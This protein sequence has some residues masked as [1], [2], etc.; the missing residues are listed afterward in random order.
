MAP[1]TP[2][3][4]KPPMK[5]ACEGRVKEDPAHK[6]AHDAISFDAVLDRLLL[7]LGSP[8]AG[9]AA[10][11]SAAS[12][13]GSWEDASGEAEAT[14]GAGDAGGP[15]GAPELDLASALASASGRAMLAGAAVGLGRAVTPAQVLARA[16]VVASRRPTLDALRAAPGVTQ[17]TPEWYEAR[18][19]MVTASDVAQ[20]LGCAKFGNQRTFFQKKCGA[21]EEQAAF[22][23]SIPPLKWGVMFEPVAQAVYTAVNGGMRVHEFGLLRHKHPALAHVGASPDGI[24]DAGV[25]LEIKC[26]WR[27]RIVEGEVPLQYYYQIQAQLAVC[28]LDECDYFECEFFEV[29]G[30]EDDQWFAAEAEAGLPHG[31]GLF[32][33]DGPGPSFS[34]PPGVVGG[35]REELEAWAEDASANA[36]L[37]SSISDDGA[38]VGVCARPPFIPRRHWWVLR[39]RC[40]SRVPYDLEF[41][42]DMFSR[43]GR[44]WERTLLYRGDRARYLEEVG[45]ATPGAAPA[46]SS[47]STSFGAFGP[48]GTADKLTTGGYAFVD[49]P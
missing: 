28:G 26:P 18:Q 6:V 31:R 30:P 15:G 9:E 5:V 40:N 11:A 29:D 27:R 24:T 33:E 17:R 20:A 3:K 1:A 42:D 38:G 46:S 13:E 35:T 41:C 25:M 37:R 4:R 36:V 39:K 49:D 48:V 45:A 21:A 10:V 16:K 8:L 14:S 34:Y 19:G 12:E 44:V 7:A 32:L 2:A 47:S 43:L 22:D 23:G